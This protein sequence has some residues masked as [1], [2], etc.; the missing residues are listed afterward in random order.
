LETLANGW[1][2]SA[3]VIARLLP[4]PGEGETTEAIPG[5]RGNIPSLLLSNNPRTGEQEGIKN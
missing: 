5:K 3:I 4:A 1:K 2:K